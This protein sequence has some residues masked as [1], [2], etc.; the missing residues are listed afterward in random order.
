MD[1]QEAG[2]IE[3]GMRDCDGCPS[4]GRGYDSP[5]AV[6]VRRPRG[7]NGKGGRFYYLCTLCAADPSCGSPGNDHVV[8]EGDLP[9]GCAWD[10]RNAV[11]A[12]SAD[13]L[14]GT[15]L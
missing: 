12:A 10:I 11:R 4:A 5:A 6:Q 13:P 2:M 8:V 7:Y 3:V 14:P 9:F 15:G 1:H